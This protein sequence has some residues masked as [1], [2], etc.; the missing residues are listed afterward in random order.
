MFHWSLLTAHMRCTA[1][2]HSGL[3][4]LHTYIYIHMYT[5]TCIHTYVN[6]YIDTYLYIHKTCIYIYIYIYICV[7]VCV[8]TCTYIVYK[9]IYLC[10]TTC[11]NNSI[12]YSELH[13]GE[14]ELTIIQQNICSY[15]LCNYSS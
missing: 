2:M 11:K 5:Y 15:Y 1:L 6:T 7:C 3:Q 14:L 9:Y 12:W 13:A 8:C 10:A 4:K